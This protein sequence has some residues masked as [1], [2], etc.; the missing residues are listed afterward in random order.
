M[1]DD[2]HIPIDCS[3]YGWVVAVDDAGLLWR[4]AAV[5]VVEEGDEVHACW[6][7]GDYCS[8]RI[9]PSQSWTDLCK[10]HWPEIER[11]KEEGDGLIEIDRL[12][13]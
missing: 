13:R 6:L 9:S 5:V 1:S 4:V 12:D 10:E 11:N 8:D 3:G 7:R 2:A